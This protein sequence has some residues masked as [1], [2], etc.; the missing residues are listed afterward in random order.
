MKIWKYEKFATTT[1]TTDNGQFWPGELKKTCKSEMLSFLDWGIFF[2]LVFKNFYIGVLLIYSQIRN[3]KSHLDW[4]SSIFR[5][6]HN[7]ISYYSVSSM[8]WYNYC[9][10][11][12]QFD[13]I[14]TQEVQYSTCLI[15]FSVAHDDIGYPVCCLMCINYPVYCCV[16]YTVYLCVVSRI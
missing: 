13:D 7:N 2:N 12:G 4:I 14:A 5:H 16:T 10:F 11:L 9:C 15:L 6:Y 1:T 3:Y 8:I